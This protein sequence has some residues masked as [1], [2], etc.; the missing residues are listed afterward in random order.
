[1]VY[2]NKAKWYTKKRKLEED[3]VWVAEGEKRET[4][5]VKKNNSGM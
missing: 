1:M 4:D 2:T 3:N 5:T